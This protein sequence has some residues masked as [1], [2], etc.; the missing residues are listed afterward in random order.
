MCGEE[1]P[2]FNRRPPTPIRNGAGWVG[3]GWGEPAVNCDHNPASLDYLVRKL[4]KLPR[5]IDAKPLGGVKIYHE[6]EL[7]RLLNRQIGGFGAL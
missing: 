2:L 3:L 7:G 4:L 6:L 5:Y 1:H